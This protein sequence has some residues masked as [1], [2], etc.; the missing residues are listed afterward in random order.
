MHIVT[1][2][3][4]L[5]KLRQQII[6][7]DVTHLT[8]EKVMRVSLLMGIGLIFFI[9]DY[10]FFRRIISYVARIDVM[11]M[12]EIGTI[13]IARLLNM[14]FLTFLSM[15]LFSNV[16][17]SLSTFYQSTDL[18]FLLSSPIRF[19]SIFTAK[20]VETMLNSSLMLLIFGI[21]IFV[22]CG[23]E[24][25]A[26]P[27]YYIA[28]PIMLLP[29]IAIPATIGISLT[30]LLARFFP[31]KRVQQVLTVFGLI[32]GAGL[33]MLFRFLRPE[34][35]V[36]EIGISQLL[37][38]IK[39]SRIPTAPYLPS[40][41]ATEVLMSLLERNPA[42]ALLNLLWLFLVAAAVYLLALR[43]AQVIYYSGWTGITESRTVKMIRRG[44]LSEKFLRRLTFL[45]STTRS[46]LM[47]DFKLFWRDTTQWS[48]LL[49]LAALLIIY[50]FNIK[51]LPLKNIYLKNLIS[52]L[53]LGLAGFVLASIGVR[54]VYPSTSLEGGSFWVVH[55]APIHYRRFL[56]E[57]FCIF[58]LPLLILG[59]LLIIISNLLLEV[60]GYM[61][62]LSAVTIFIITIGL[63]G[64]G[65][66][67]GAIYPKF[68]NENPAQIAMSIGGILYMILSLA[69]IGVTIV[70]EA[71][72]VYLYF[73]QQLS[74]EAISGGETGLYL[75]YT[76]VF[77]LSVCVTVIPLY[78]GVKRLQSFEIV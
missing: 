75:A 11:D 2:L 66:G 35:L 45:H 33:V 73:S 12:V 62:M 44:T 77:G 15:L 42:H 51:S 10:L 37:L 31:V 57:K 72:P 5:S 7:N 56:L 71:W 14:I 23:Q 49:M 3:R 27:I 8:K 38:Y 65:V 61:M 47:K 74:R 59:E 34:Q 58:L 43:L 6:K 54:F 40:T 46:L 13:L 16:V 25:G 64:L 29:F 39:N 50:F 55:S 63:T 70:L 52:F 4:L 69:Y 41:W 19:V 24:Y 68:I 20:L 30:M 1:E 17:L 28:I 48:Q 32:L 21:P 36:D 67:M 9:L 60:E 76:L 78:L 18:P 53:N 26:S 22:V